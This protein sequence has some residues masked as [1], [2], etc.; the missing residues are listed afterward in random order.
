MTAIDLPSKIANE[1]HVECEIQTQAEIWMSYG[2]QTVGQPNIGLKLHVYILRVNNEAR[3]R[4]NTCCYQVTVYIY[5]Y[6]Y[7]CVYKY[8]C[9]YMNVYI[10]I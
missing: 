8:I 9:I 4:Y 1:L 6:I 10:N 2:R 7:V 5:I 3:S